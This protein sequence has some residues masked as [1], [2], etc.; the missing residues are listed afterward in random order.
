MAEGLKLKEMNGW[1]T[2]CVHSV[3]VAKINGTNIVTETGIDS[4]LFR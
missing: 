4:S 2:E 3:P 1:N